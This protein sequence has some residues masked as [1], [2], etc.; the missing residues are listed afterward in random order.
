MYHGVFALARGDVVA[1]QRRERD[2]DD[3]VQ[4]EFCGESAVFGVDRVEGFA[5]VVDHVEL[6]DREH[7]VADAEQRNEDSCAGASA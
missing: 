6:V 4:L 1:A 7:D 5:R 3:V 2:A